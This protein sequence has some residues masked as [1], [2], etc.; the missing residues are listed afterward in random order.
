MRIGARSLDRYVASGLVMFV[1]LLADQ[2]AAMP[3]QGIGSLPTQAADL[4]VQS[5]GSQADS[6]QPAD[7]TKKPV[8]TAAAPYERPTGIAASKPA[9]AAIAPAKQRRVRT[10]LISV[11]VVVGIGVA[12]GTI[13]ALS[14]ASP[15]RPN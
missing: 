5:N 4:G 10:I 1:L 2:H 12:L 15:S 11:G 7:G 14:H 9:G 3:Q 13:V 6:D 8:G